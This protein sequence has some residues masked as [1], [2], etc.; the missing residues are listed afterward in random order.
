MERG[1]DTD[2]D[3]VLLFKKSSVMKATISEDCDSMGVSS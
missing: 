2:A 3:A 1:K